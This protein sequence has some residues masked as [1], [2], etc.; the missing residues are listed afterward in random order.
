MKGK[1][2]RGKGKVQADIAWVPTYKRESCGNKRRKKKDKKERRLRKKRG[3]G[4]TGQGPKHDHQRQTLQLFHYK[5]ICPGF[6]IL[7]SDIVISDSL[8]QFLLIILSIRS[9]GFRTC[10]DHQS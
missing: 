3:G 6:Q 10:S 5:Y 8:T 9:T 7:H 1:G 2:K 4:I